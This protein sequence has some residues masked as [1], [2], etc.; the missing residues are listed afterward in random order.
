[1]FR[2]ESTSTL[3]LVS[4]GKVHIVLKPAKTRS[5]NGGRQTQH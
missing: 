1:M 4:S 3:A 2:G 5:D